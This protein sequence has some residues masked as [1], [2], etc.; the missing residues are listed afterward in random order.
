[1]TTEPELLRAVLSEPD[2]DS[3]RIAFADW[4][5]EQGETERAEFIRV[6]V[7]LAVETRKTYQVRLKRRLKQM[8]RGVVTLRRWTWTN[9]VLDDLG[10]GLSINGWPFCVVPVVPHATFRRGFVHAITCAAANFLEH[11]DSLCWHPKQK[12]R[13]CDGGASHSPPFRHCDECNCTGE[14]SCP[15]TAQPI[16]EVTLT[17]WPDPNRYPVLQEEGGSAL[18]AA[19]LAAEWPGINFRLP[20]QT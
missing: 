16:R 13:A 2:S 20:D 5:E 7:A 3:P 10:W 6:Q 19:H 15:E 17:K 9:Y 8:C 14:R 1:M 4:L 18:F 11:A 12:C